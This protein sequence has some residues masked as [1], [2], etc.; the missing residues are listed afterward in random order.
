MSLSYTI[1]P[2]LCLP[3]P[4][5][6]VHFG[7]DVFHW[8]IAV[9]ASLSGVNEIFR[10]DCLPLKPLH[11]FDDVS[12]PEFDRALVI[13]IPPHILESVQFPHPAIPSVLHCRHD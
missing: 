8:R 3:L 6:S 5:C 4:V 11:A 7:L 12:T 10:I 1:S 2:G 13:V 9:K